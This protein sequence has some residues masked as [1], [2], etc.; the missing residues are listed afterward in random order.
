[1]KNNNKKTKKLKNVKPNDNNQITGVRMGLV[2]VQKASTRENKKSEQEN[3][4]LVII[5]SRRL[6]WVW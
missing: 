5:R 2:E 1:M 6:G 3:K 4:K